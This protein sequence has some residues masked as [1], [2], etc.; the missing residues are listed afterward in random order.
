VFQFCRRTEAAPIYLLL[1]L[2]SMLRVRAERTGSRI[3]FDMCN[4]PVIRG[5][6]R[7]ARAGWPK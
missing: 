1:Y 4:R 3:V 7:F 5:V 6:L 2:A